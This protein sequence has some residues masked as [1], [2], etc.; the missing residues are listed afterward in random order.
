MLTF[1]ALT[2]MSL[3]R[4]HESEKLNE[5]TRALF[6]NA[7]TS[8]IV[9]GGG[10]GWVKFF[11]EYP[12][13]GYLHQISDLSF[14]VTKYVVLVASKPDCVPTSFSLKKKSLDG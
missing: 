4:S 12:L 11:N 13:V 2:F 1:R 8:S 9:E 3:L 10:R 5:M 14:D 6:C 7:I